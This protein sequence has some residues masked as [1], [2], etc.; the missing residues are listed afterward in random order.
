MGVF[1]ISK[2]YNCFS[3]TFF[4]SLFLYLPCQYP[5]NSDENHRKAASVQ[6]SSIHSKPITG[7]SKLVQEDY[8]R[9]VIS[10]TP[11]VA[12]CSTSFLFQIVTHISSLSNKTIFS[13]THPQQLNIAIILCF[14]WIFPSKA[15]LW[16]FYGVTGVRLLRLVL[17][18]I[19][20]HQGHLSLLRI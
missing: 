19:L 6:S 10:A 9:P 16:Y 18:F 11:Y 4:F 2:N 1:S 14:C 13:M 7:S 8:E 12:I 17:S 5:I 3:G 15:H 20:R